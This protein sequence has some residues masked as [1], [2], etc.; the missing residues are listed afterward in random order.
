MSTKKMTMISKKDFLNQI[1]QLVEDIGDIKLI[2]HK[3]DGKHRTYWADGVKVFLV[4]DTS[5]DK[6]YYKF[7]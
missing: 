1:T 4:S 2:K 5:P 3:S 6:T 7:T